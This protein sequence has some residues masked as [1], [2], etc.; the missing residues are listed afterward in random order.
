MR[1]RYGSELGSPAPG[2]R[3]DHVI[4][5]DGRGEIGPSMIFNRKY[6]GF[7]A[8]GPVQNMP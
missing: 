6:G 1:N 3:A 5:L 2:D 8:Q 7:G 4:I